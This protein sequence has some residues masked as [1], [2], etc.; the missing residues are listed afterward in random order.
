MAA[1]VVIRSFHGVAG[2]TTNDIDNG[3]CR[4][5]LADN[6]TV[7]ANNPIVIVAGQTKYSYLKQFKFRITATP[8]SNS[9]SNLRVHSDGANGLGTGVTILVGTNASYLDPVAN[10]DAAVGSL[11]DIFT[12]HGSLGAALAVTG[13]GSS[14]NTDV[15]NYVRMQMQVADSASQGTTPTETIS[16][17]FDES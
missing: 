8:P 17:V 15:G 6:D 13:S 1:S 11:A 12:T 9:I 5:K 4:F 2:A 14:A 3:N 16:F 10:A 7:D